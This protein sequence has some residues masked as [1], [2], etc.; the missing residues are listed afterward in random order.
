MQKKHELNI[1]RLKKN[2][3]TALK[4]YFS[5]EVQLDCSTSQ[6]CKTNRLHKIRKRVS[7]SAKKKYE[8]S[9][10]TYYESMLLQ[11][12]TGP[13]HVTQYLTNQLS[14]KGNQ[15]YSLLL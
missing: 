14:I 1:H 9:R 3:I 10:E 8:C 15:V 12:K 7:E 13:F 4:T 6:Q 2:R 5:D 11:L